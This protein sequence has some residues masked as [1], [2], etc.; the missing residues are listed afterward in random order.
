MKVA[1]PGGLRHKEVVALRRL[2]VAQPRPAAHHV[3][4][5]H[6]HFRPGDVGEALGHQA[7]TGTGRGR[8]HAD[9][10][11]CRAVDHVDGGDFAFGLQKDAAFVGHTLGEV[12]QRLALRR[13]G[14]TEVGLQTVAQ[15]RFREGDVT[16]EE[17]FGHYADAP[18]RP[19]GVHDNPCGS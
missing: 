12:F 2:D 9:A 8:H 15:G 14:I 1:V 10:G 18:L 5:D 17:F 4:D 13:D 16:F 7:E 6:G 19:R 3:D 11:A